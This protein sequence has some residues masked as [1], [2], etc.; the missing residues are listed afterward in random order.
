MNRN[1]IFLTALMLLLAVG[2]LFLSKSDQQKQMEPDKLLWEIIQPTRYMST[3]EVAKILIQKDPSIELIDV[4]TPKEFDYFSLPNAINLPLDSITTESSQEYFGIPGMNV[5]F[6]S[7][8]AIQ[9]D[10]AWVMVKRLGFDATYVMKGGLNRWIETIIQA[11][12]PTSGEARKAFELY[13][14]RKGAQ[15]YF[16]G[17]KV[18]TSKAVNKHK[19]VVQRKKKK[20]VASGGC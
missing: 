18:E 4:R 11:K 7:N 20:A 9:A 15:L 3:D 10:Q 17:A 2:T 6:F 8:D 1:Y 5:I 12:E 14:F 16:T 19:V 13:Q